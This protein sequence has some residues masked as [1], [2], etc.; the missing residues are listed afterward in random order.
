MLTCCKCGKE[1]RGRFCFINSKEEVVDNPFCLEHTIE[2]FHQTKRSLIAIHSSTSV[3][4]DFILRQN[5]TKEPPPIPA[6]RL[7]LLAKGAT[8]EA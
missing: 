1:A 4:R 8:Y 5:W 2:I 7:E 6:T 3:D